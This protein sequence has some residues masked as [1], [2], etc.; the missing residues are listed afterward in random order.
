MEVNS[1]SPWQ[2]V[3]YLGRL[4]SRYYSAQLSIP[5]DARNC[6]DTVPLTSRP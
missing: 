6:T 4:G 5:M 2:V 1:G 3:Y